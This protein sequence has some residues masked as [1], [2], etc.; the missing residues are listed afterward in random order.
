MTVA[1]KEQA[2]TTRPAVGEGHSGLTKAAVFM[3]TIG[4][5][6]AGKIMQ[7]MDRQTVEDLTRE[8]ASLGT[9]HYD[10]R[11]QV[12]EEFYH[13][14]LADNY[15]ADGGLDYARSIVEKALPK[16]EVKRVMEEIEYQ[17][18]HKPFSILQQ[19]EIASLLPFLQ[20]EHPQTIALIIAHLPGSKGS[21]IL[22]GLPPARQVEVV[23]RV[24]NMEHSD[25][26]AIREVEKCLE[27]R[28]SGRLSPKYGR[29]GGV[30]T[31][32]EILNNVDR[33]TE[34]NIL[35]SL[36]SHDPDLAERIRRSMFTF[37]DILRVNDK[38]IQSLLKEVSHEEL[39]LALKTASEPLKEKI[40]KSMSQRA[41]TLIGEEMEYMG[42]VRL[43]SVEE[44]QHKICDVVRRLEDSGDLIVEGRGSESD[45][46]V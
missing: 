39:A 11:E 6:T 42:P 5:D 10:E 43:S 2:P 12:L 13:T 46:V 37:E 35:D 16:D 44:A 4:P 20:E 30:E 7:H 28:L 21:E 8:I 18:T 15:T 19:A 26:E 22:A 41:S 1:Q 3:L 33:T 14:C 36:E 9:V 24:L 45:I 29:V 34:T 17:V 32:A 23:N 25:P 27:E 31:V 38:G 40:L